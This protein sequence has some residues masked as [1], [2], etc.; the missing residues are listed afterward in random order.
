MPLRKKIFIGVGG[1]VAA[2]LI[3]VGTY[4]ALHKPSD[5]S[6]NNTATNS[7]SG[8]NSTASNEPASTPISQIDNSS[9]AQDLTAIN[10]NVTGGDSNDTA[11]DAAL[12][13]KS[14]EITVQ[15][16]ATGGENANNRLSRIKSRGDAEIARRLDA[17]NRAIMAVSGASN[18]SDEARDTLNTEIGNEV[19]GLAALRIK[20]ENETA[21]A[22]AASDISNMVTE[23]RVYALLVPK[24]RLVRTADN[25][26]A[27]EQ[28]L[29]DLYA[30]LKKRAAQTQVSGEGISLLQTKVNELGSQIDAA[31]TLSN[32]AE[33]GLLPLQPTDYNTDHGILSAYRDKLKTA[34][35]HNKTAA[36]L[37]KEI[38]KGL[39]N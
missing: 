33:A 2:A 28:K 20:L 13:D 26:I 11:A 9:L 37:A 15:T 35:E 25:Q 27:V 18:L 23:Y 38:V 29:S 34:H 3:A 21:V 5:T 16:D 10:A 7:L 8:D 17:L 24:A 4:T 6:K 39:K 32:D 30:K 12:N 14:K 19:A 22:A 1:V 36:S 31:K